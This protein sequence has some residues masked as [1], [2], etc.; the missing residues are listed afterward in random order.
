MIR[1]LL[2]LICILVAIILSIIALFR[3]LFLLL[4]H[5]KSFIKWSIILFPIYTFIYFLFK[6]HV[7]IP[8]ILTSCICGV[9]DAVLR[10]NEIKIG[11]FGSDPMRVSRRKQ[12]RL[13]RSLRRRAVEPTITKSSGSN[14]PLALAG[15]AIAIGST[16]GEDSGS[17]YSARS[18]STCGGEYT[19]PNSNQVYDY[20]AA[21]EDMIA[22]LGA[23][24]VINTKTKIVHNVYDPSAKEIAFKHRKYTS[25]SQ[26]PLESEGYRFKNQ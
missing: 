23:T 19:G 11:P 16:L 8:Y 13:E 22:S 10:R 4:K 6:V 2:T 14:I 15:L 12:R 5:S 26:Y 3:L 1:T 21:S 25:D 17:S 9:I 24:H 20:S 18:R 7:F